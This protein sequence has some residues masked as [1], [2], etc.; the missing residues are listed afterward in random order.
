MK[1][2]V[3]RARKQMISLYSTTNSTENQ[4][5]FTTSVWSSQYRTL[6]YTSKRG[7]KLSNILLCLLLAKHPREQLSICSDKTM[8]IRQL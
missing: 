3:P 1:F 5:T 6:F 7:E 2:Y 8:T 4:R